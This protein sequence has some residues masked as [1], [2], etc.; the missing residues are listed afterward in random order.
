M[1]F[2]LFALLP[3]F[4]SLPAVDAA[5]NDWSIPCTRGECYYDMP[6]ADGMAT[7]SMKIVRFTIFILHLYQ[8]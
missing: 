5:T 3:F 6:S 7:G 8:H 2:A 4:I 1:F